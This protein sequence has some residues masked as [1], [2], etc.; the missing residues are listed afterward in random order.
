MKTTIRGDVAKADLNV[1]VVFEGLVEWG[2]QFLVARDLGAVEGFREGLS[3]NGEASAVNDAT[4][5]QMAKAS[6]CRR[7]GGGHA[8]CHCPGGKL[9]STGVF[10]QIA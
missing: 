7:G 4:I 10:R 1:G 9:Q 8:W 5:E 6:R 3:G 2:D